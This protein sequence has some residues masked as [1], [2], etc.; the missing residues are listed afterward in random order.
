MCMSL[1]YMYM[2]FVVSRVLGSIPTEGAAF[3]FFSLL[4]HQICDK[5]VPRLYQGWDNFKS[6]VLTR[7]GWL[8]QPLA[9]LAATRLLQP[10]HF[11]MGYVK[12]QIYCAINCLKSLEGHS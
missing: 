12:A 11:C 4:V 2:Q 9:N 6:K 1:Y 8:A 7:L 10:W 3:F 5:V